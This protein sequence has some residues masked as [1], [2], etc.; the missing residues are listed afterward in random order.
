MRFAYEDLSEHQF[1]MLVVHICQ[2][3]LGASVQGFSKGPDGGRDARF[4]GTAQMI[5]SEAEPWKGKVII[6]AKHTIAY[7]QT[8]SEAGFFSKNGESSIV[9]KEVPR[10]KALRE[11]SEL[12]HY[13]LFANRRLSAGAESE[14]RNHIAEACGL[15][16]GSITLCGT[17]QLETWLKRFPEAATEAGLDPVDSPLL[18]S[19]DD[20]AKLVQAIHANRETIVAVVA[21]PPTT[22]TSYEEKNSKNN[23]TPTY[24]KEL[25]SMY[26]KDSQVVR[27]FLSNPENVEYLRLYEG[28]VEEFQLKIVANRKDFQTFDKVMEY[29]VDL[30]FGRDPDLKRNRRLTRVTLFYM[31]WNCDIGEVAENAAAD[32]ALSS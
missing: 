4:E 15:P 32:E 19:P 5:P 24:A 1:E 10:I 28:I 30:L 16:S 21:H 9:A 25:R 6:Q 29:L 26:L 23:M 2:R 7:N 3:L 13:M 8:F 12:D 22:R 27:E 20:L 17:E 11:R 18:V 14:I 31:Y